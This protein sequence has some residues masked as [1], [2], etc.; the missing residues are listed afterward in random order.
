MDVGVEAAEDRN[1]EGV[2]VRVDGEHDLPAPC[3]PLSALMEVLNSVSVRMER[4]TMSGP[5]M[6]HTLTS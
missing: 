3:Y 2:L 6:L 4:E 1:D 5:T